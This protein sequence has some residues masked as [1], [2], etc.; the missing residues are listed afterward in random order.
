VGYLKVA[1]A[2]GYLY[3]AHERNEVVS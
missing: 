1:V 2:V 3:G